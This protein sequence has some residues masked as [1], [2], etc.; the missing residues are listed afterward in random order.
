MKTKKVTLSI[1]I[2]HDLPESAMQLAIS[3]ALHAAKRS[4]LGFSDAD[5]HYIRTADDNAT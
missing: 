2:E 5:G 3:E 1:V 4:L